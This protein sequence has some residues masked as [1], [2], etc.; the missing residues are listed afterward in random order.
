MKRLLLLLLVSTANA[1]T[2][3]EFTTIPPTITTNTVLGNGTSATAAPQQLAAPT[4][5]TSASALKWTTNTGFGCNTAID[6]ATLLTGTWAA[7]GS[8]GSGTPAAGAFTTLSASAPFTLTLGTSLS[9][10]SWLNAGIGLVVPAATFNDTTAGS[11]GVAND[12]AYAFAAP[13]TTNTQGS[14]NTL[15]NLTTLFVAAPVCGSGWTACT[16]TYSIFSNGR[17]T[18]SGGMSTSGAIN[19]FNV[20]SNFATNINTGTSNQNVNIGNSADTVAIGGPMTVAGLITP[21]ATQ[22]IKGTVAADSPAVGSVGEVVSLHCVV[23]AAAAAG[24]AVSLPVASPGVVTWSGHTFTTSTGLA[25]YSC[26]IN[27]LANGGALP[28]G[29][30][31]GTTY[32]IIGSTV[33]GDTFQ[34]ADTAAHALAGTN[35]VNFTGSP[36]GSPL[37][38]IGGFGQNSTVLAGT[39]VALVAGDWDCTYLSEYQEVTSLTAAEYFSAIDTAIQ[40][41]TIGNGSEVRFVS[42]VFGAN[43]AYL[44]SPTIRYNISGTTNIFGIDRMTFSGGSV[45]LG[46]SFRCRRMR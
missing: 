29:L 45:N 34:V 41:T 9:Q 22:G 1:Q 19:N 27:F 7:P 14:G 25:N 39:S 37:A 20:S 35:A 18:T 28:T 17:I 32:Y 31:A 4:C 38:Y 36:S 44:V 46:G 42:G 30:A 24:S 10:A 23:G 16:N 3:Y 11:G 43:N 15:T 8:I 2:T 5:S 6:A 21:T 40:G 26:P 33:S 13:T 12:A